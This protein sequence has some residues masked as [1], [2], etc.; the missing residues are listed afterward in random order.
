[1]S[2]VT[3]HA[4]HS[5]SPPFP[6]TPPLLALGV[7]LGGTGGGTFGFASESA[8]VGRPTRTAGY[9]VGGDVMTGGLETGTVVFV[10][11]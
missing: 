10:I 3:R 8:T 6:L 5:L 2:Y 1:M 9:A 7:P 4:Y 11:V